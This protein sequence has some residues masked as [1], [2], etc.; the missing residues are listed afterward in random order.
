MLRKAF[1]RTE[2]ALLALILGAMTL[3]TM[4][5]VIQRYVFNSGFIWALE[6]DFYLFA[7]LVLIG[8]A[9][10]VRVKAHIGVDAAVSLLP[11]AGRRAVGLVVVGLALLYAGLMIYG[12]W[13]Y[14]RR[15][16]ILGVEAEDIPVQRWI[17]T[18]CLPIG[19]ALLFFRLLGM[20]WR[21]VTG[22][23]IGYELADEAEEAIR[24]YGGEAGRDRPAERQ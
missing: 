17:L 1:E 12:S 24:E 11:A 5:Q 19:F 22:R 3:L 21:V 20:G 23:S 8:L 14:V 4:L 16:F 15:L 2:E 6:A 13:G 10:G 7:W 9:Y 18:L